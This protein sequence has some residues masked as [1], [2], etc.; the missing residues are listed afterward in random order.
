MAVAGEV[1]PSQL[2][3]TFGIG[4]TLDLPEVSALVM[5]LDYWNRDLCRPIIEHRLLAAVQRIVGSQVQEIASSPC[6]GGRE[7][8]QGGA[9]RPLSPL[10]ALQRMRG[11]GAA[12]TGNL[13]KA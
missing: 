4:A 13:R 8:Q 3:F 7:R 11:Y 1:R 5:G 10:D 6:T 12:G 2:M 9:C